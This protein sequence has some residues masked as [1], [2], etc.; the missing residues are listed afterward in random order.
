MIKKNQD[1]HLFAGAG[2]EPQDHD[3]ASR[4]IDLYGNEASTSADPAVLAA[5]IVW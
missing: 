2:A 5:V 4:V 1:L 3:W